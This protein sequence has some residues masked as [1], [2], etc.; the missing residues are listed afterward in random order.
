MKLWHFV[1]PRQDLMESFGIAGAYVPWRL[2]EKNLLLTEHL[3]EE[4]QHRTAEL[5]A[6]LNERKAFFSDLAHNLKAPMAAIHGF[7]N[8]ILLG[9]LY[10]DDDLRGY[11]SKISG[12]NEELCRRM[13]ALGDLN[14]FDKITEPYRCL[15]VNEILSQVYADNA[16]EATISGIV[17]YVGK[18]NL[19]ALVYAQK[20]SFCFYLKI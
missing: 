16:P 18:L 11:L 6:V 14:A 2:L 15:D 9:N 20:K 13:Q 8:L 12:A 17:F 19:P 10:L 7:T 5:H 1:L 4:V 3:E